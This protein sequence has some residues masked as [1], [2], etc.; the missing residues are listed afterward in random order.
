VLFGHAEAG[1]ALAAGARPVLVEGPFDA[2][3]VSLA[4][5]GQYV[6]VAPMGTA[7]TDTQADQ[8]RPFLAPDRP[9]LIVATDADRAGRAAAERAFWQLTARANRLPD[10]GALNHQSISAA[11]ALLDRIRDADILELNDTD[12]TE[13]TTLIARACRLPDPGAVDHLELPPG[14]DPA[15][16]LHTRGPQALHAAL[17]QPASLARTLVDRILDAY[18]RELDDVHVALRA[19]RDAAALIAVLPVEQWPSLIDH[20]VARAG[21]LDSSTV[22]TVCEQSEAWSADPASYARQRL[23][24][25]RTR[26][27]MQ[28]VC[29]SRA[30]TA[31]AFAAR[32][33]TRTTDARAATEWVLLGSAAPGRTPAAPRSPAPPTPVRRPTPPPPTTSARP[34]QRPAAPRR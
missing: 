34:Q 25:Q 17:E 10:P 32:P 2:I 21:I 33:D 8:L 23:T 18:T 29:E 24:Q 30:R 22:L 1:P 19:M 12:I 26:E 16:L 5:A 28:E 20:V 7:L 31:A 27:R 11:R 3:A 15:D 4:G 9:G 13:Q 6:G 14:L